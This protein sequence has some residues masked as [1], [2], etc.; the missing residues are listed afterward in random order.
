MGRVVFGMGYFCVKWDLGGKISCCRVS[1]AACALW[2]EKAV[3]RN[4]EQ[5]IVKALLALLGETDGHIY[6]LACFTRFP[7][8]ST[9]RDCRRVADLD[10]IYNPRE[11]ERQPRHETELG[12]EQHQIGI[13]GQSPRLKS[14]LSPA[15]RFRSVKELLP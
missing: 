3:Y 7:E 4:M 10:V 13:Q 2:H 1:S 11:A 12:R 8:F 15:V 5:G 14:F 9:C 6:H